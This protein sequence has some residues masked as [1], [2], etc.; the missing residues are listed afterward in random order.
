MIKL[1][2]LFRDGM[3]LQQGVPVKIWG[4]A[5][6]PVTVSVDMHSAVDYACNG[7]FSLTLP[8]HDAGGPYTMFVE[9]AGEV[10]KI[11]DVY[12]GEVFLAGGQSNM[13]M[14]L[15]D[16]YQPLDSAE[17][18]V[19]IFTTDREWEYS[20]RPETDERWIEISEENKHGISA[21]ASHFEIAL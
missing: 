21:T 18:P 19:R 7:K 3:I 20:R 12:F 11:H 5:D 2:K 10:S 16:L 4:E 13:A 6:Y 1:N 17:Y 8:A 9:C 15:E 14:T